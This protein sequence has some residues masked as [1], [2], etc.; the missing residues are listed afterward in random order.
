MSHMP[1]SHPPPPMPPPPP[2]PAPKPTHHPPNHILSPILTMDN[3]GS[4]SD[5]PEEVEVASSDPERST[6][7]A[8]TV[9]EGVL[10]TPT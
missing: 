4:I 7:K 2:P 3:L 6:E 1:A 5:F 10:A 9:D 8:T